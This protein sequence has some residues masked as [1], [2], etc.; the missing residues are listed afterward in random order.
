MKRFLFLL[1]T[2]SLLVMVQIQTGLSGQNDTSQTS[3]PSAS[4]NMSGGIFLFF[5]ANAIIHL[6]CFS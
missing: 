3:S 6:F 5:V 4:S 1:L 2:I